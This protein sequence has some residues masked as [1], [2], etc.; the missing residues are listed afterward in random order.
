M[1]ESPAAEMTVLCVDDSPMVADAL[2]AK[3][4]RTAGFAWKGWLPE[5]TQ[6]ITTILDQGCPDIVLLDVDM[7][8]K[9]PFK[10]LAEL[11]ETCSSIRVV[12]FSGHVRRELI[13][14]A[15]ECGAWGYVSKN[16]GEESLIS[17]LRS[18]AR[19]E[20]ALS[21]EASRIFYA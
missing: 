3:L 10:A 20:F 7:P 19:D 14:R 15:V 6:L 12:I 5:A 17:V 18:V 8:G 16:D 1:T 11:V 21:P 4:S 2:R 9:D 13:D